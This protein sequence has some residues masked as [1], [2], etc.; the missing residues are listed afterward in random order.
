MQQFLVFLP[1]F[2][3]NLLAQC[4]S[5]CHSFFDGGLLPFPASVSCAS[6]AGSIYIIGAPHFPVKS[7]PPR[8][9]ITPRPTIGL[10]SWSSRTRRRLSILINAG[11]LA[12][13]DR[14]RNKLQACRIHGRRISWWVHGERHAGS[15]VAIARL[16]RRPGDAIHRAAC[17]RRR[18]ARRLPRPRSADPNTVDKL[19]AHTRYRLFVGEAVSADA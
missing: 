18:P 7:F 8:R 2:I 1:R 13:G 12:A 15:A 19:R 3:R 5:R 4:N 9:V 6:D 16:L 17:H 14:L 11:L 10:I